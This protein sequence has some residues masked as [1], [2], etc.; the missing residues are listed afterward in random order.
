MVI[1]VI[2]QVIMKELIV[3]H[4]QL[5]LAPTI[6]LATEHA[7]EKQENVHVM[8]I[9]KK[10]IVPKFGFVQ[11]MMYQNLNVVQSYKKTAF[12]IV[13]VKATAVKME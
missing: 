5:F 11:W 2:V 3:R 4:P 1:N 7:M 13:G 8:L 6:V 9:G 12:Q 10:K